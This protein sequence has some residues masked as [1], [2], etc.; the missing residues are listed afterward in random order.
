MLGDINMPIL[1]SRDD[2]M[3]NEAPEDVKEGQ[4]VILWAD[5]L[6][7]LYPLWLGDMPA[8]AESVSGT[9]AAPWNRA[10]IW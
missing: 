9:G 4:E 3:H 10:A 6:V 8:L 1:H 5:H 7:F 2:W